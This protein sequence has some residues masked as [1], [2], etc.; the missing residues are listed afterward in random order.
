[1]P[2]TILLLIVGLLLLWVVYQGS[3]ATVSLLSVK[4]GSGTHTPPSEHF[5]LELKGRPS[6]AHRATGTRPITV[7]PVSTTT[8]QVDIGRF[9]IAIGTSK[10]SEDSVPTA[11]ELFV[12]SVAAEASALAW[13][14]VG[15]PCVVSC[16]YTV[17]TESVRR[18]AQIRLSLTVSGFPLSSEQQRA[19]KNVLT[20]GEVANS[21]AAAVIVDVASAQTGDTTIPRS[22]AGQAGRS[23]VA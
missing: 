11:E 14:T 13:Q 9:R 16:R 15:Q 4:S 6:I 2:T 18:V 1:M 20:R 21:V 19:L 5:V 22:P 10:A 12:A 7:T 17:D 23:R 3:R 8:Q